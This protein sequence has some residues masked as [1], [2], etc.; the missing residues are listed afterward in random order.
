M[1]GVQGVDCLKAGGDVAGGGMAGGLVRRS[2]VFTPGVGEGF[3]CRKDCF[4]PLAEI[5]FVLFQRFIWLSW[6]MQRGGPDWDIGI[7]RAG[8]GGVLTVRVK[9]GS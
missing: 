8:R 1:T 6:L 3:D 5:F 4:C 2:G 7:R 9:V